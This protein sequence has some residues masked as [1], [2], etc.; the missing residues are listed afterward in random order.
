MQL[1]SIF[2]CGNVIRA[3]IL[4][5]RRDV[6]MCKTAGKLEFKERVLINIHV[7]ISRHNIRPGTNP[8]MKAEANGF[9][10]AQ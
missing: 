2:C 3:I 10:P 9:G 6:I 5:T 8:C 1:S 7:Y 4:P